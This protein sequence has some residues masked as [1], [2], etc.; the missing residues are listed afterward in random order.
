MIRNALIFL[1]LS[2]SLVGYA[3]VQVPNGRGGN[4]V[5]SKLQKPKPG[6][7]TVTLGRTPIRVKFQLAQSARVSIGVYSKPAGKLVRTLISGVQMPAGVVPAVWKGDDDF[8]NAAP[9]GDYEFRMLSSNVEYKWLGALGN[10]SFNLANQNQMQRGYRRI[11]AMTIVGTKA[12]YAN[13]Y[14]E[15]HP[16]QAYFDLATPQVRNEY[17]PGG[18]TGQATRFITSDGVNVY[19]AGYDF[20]SDRKRLNFIFA[21]KVSDNTQTTFSSGV[22]VKTA[23]G[24]EWGFTYNSCMVADTSGLPNNTDIYKGLTVQKSGSYLFVSYGIQNKVR[25]YNKTTAAFVRDISVTNPGALLIDGANDNALWVVSN[26]VLTKRTINGDGTLGSVLLTLP[27][28]GKPLAMGIKP[29][30]SVISVC[31]ADTAQKVKHYNASTGVLISS[32][33]I[34]G[35]YRNDPSVTTDKFYFD[36]VPLTIN[37]T[38]LAYA[39]DGSYWVGDDGNYRTLHFS[40]TGTYLEQIAFMENCYTTGVDKNN[41]TRLFGQWMEFS[42]SDYDNPTVTSSWTLVKNYRSMIPGEY[43]ENEYNRMQNIFQV[44]V[45]Q[46]VVTHQGHTYGIIQRAGNKLLT[47]IEL[48]PNAPVRFTGITL[49]QMLQ[50]NNNIEAWVLMK[51][52]SLALHRMAGV[53][54]DT[55]YGTEKWVRR[56]FTGLDGNGNPTWAPEVTIEEVAVTPKDPVPV[57]Q[58]SVD[59]GITD[60][61]VLIAYNPTLYKLSTGAGMGYHLGGVKN[62]QWSWGS[63]MATSPDYLGDYPKDGAYDIGNQVQYGGGNASVVENHI[64]PTYH[65]EFWK[66]LQT[67]KFDHFYENGLYVGGFGVTGPDARNDPANN[68]GMAG[69]V[70]GATAVKSSNGNIY[71]VHGEE[72][73]WSGLHIWR[74]KNLNT[75]Q[76]QTITATLSNEPD[77]RGTPMFAALPKY[78][79]LAT[80]AISGF[81]RSPATDNGE[82]RVRTN[83]LSYARTAAPDFYFQNNNS[84]GDKY[85]TVPF[86]SATGLTNW[87]ISFTLQATQY[88]ASVGEYGQANSG[89]GYI[90]ILDA[91]GKILV[92]YYQKEAGG[93]ARNVGF[94]G[95]QAASSIQAYAPITMQAVGSNIICTYGNNPPVTVPKFDNTATLTSPASIQVFSW[96]N[97]ESTGRIYGILDAWFKPN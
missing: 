53:N 55:G 97:G 58:G 38:F 12:Y 77:T 44:N 91:A 26:N 39:P 14:C 72:F 16:S 83:A 96:I 31:D 2:L 35:G 79:T 66:G 85:A 29:D 94:N 20:F 87:K 78:T 74:V 51:D 47:V 76:I 11:Q 62:G 71:L 93:S 63:H 90:R 33:G 37:D 69:N 13:G 15:G 80:G 22:Q 57:S 75:I 6:V 3:Q 23:G 41:S 40:S 25:V 60:S 8:G 19:Y 28:L 49:G 18:K 21:T 27:N 43:F 61:G 24:A 48:M 36:D 67:N 89:G 64:F 54:V 84:S 34:K 82:Y 5:R 56:A 10:T 81:V 7:V 59:F 46:Q 86:N 9:A 92:Q 88:R 45:L 52:G 65:G 4:V 50:G 95:V 17:F 42:V 73:G 70:F 30:N 1:C 68:P 32:K